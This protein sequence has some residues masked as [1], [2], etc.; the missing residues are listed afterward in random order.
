MSVTITELIHNGTMSA[1]MAA[2][3]WAAVDEQ[4]SFLTVALPRLAGKS[5][6]SMAALA[7]RPPEMPAVRVAGEAAV[8]E[9]LRHE[10]RGG[11][12][13]VDEFSRA[14]I[15]GYI[16]GAPVQRVFDT[17][18][19]GYALQTSLHAPDVEEGILQVTRGN[20]ISDEQAS[21]FKLVVFIERFGNTYESLWRR[22]TEL[23]E[24]H[25]V[26]NGRP[27]GHPLYRW[28][29]H[30]DSFEKLTDPHQFGREPG[31]LA[32]RSDLLGGLARAGHTSDEALAEALTAFRARR[33]GTVED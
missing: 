15:P 31:D 24:V 6:T 28:N 21:T 26:E 29:R 30:D 32:E 5:T 13:V 33:N 7:L 18:P 14:P 27:I 12:L 17:L 23:Y 16:W 11:Y 20:G 3:L 22:V 8:M 10:Q 4:L 25:A 2:V 1:D 9:R 19:Y